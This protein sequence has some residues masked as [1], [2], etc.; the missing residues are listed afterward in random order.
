MSALTRKVDRLPKAKLHPFWK[1]H[2]DKVFNYS[3]MFELLQSFIRQEHS[4]S[5]TRQEGAS[6]EPE[7]FRENGYQRALEEL[8]RL[9][10]IGERE[11]DRERTG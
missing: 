8:Y 3:E 7:W 6:F 9:T 4:R 5:L 11:N 10:D 2:K 1:E